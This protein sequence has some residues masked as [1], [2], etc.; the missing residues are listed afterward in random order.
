[1]KLEPEEW[2]GFMVIMDREG[3]AWG[4]TYAERTYLNGRGED[5]ACIHC[6]K[7]TSSKGKAMGVMVGEGGCAF[8][9]PEDYENY[10]H[11]NGEMGWF[12]VGR[13]CIKQIPSEYWVEDPYN[14]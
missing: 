2:E 11:R 14:G 5:N 7:R 8:I 13:E 4:P 1:M 10:P 3:W 9:R 12:P 6:G